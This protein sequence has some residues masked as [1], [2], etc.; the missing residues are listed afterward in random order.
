MRFCSR[1]EHR[2]AVQDRQAMTDDSAS[3]QMQG[4]EVWCLMQDPVD[5]GTFI[6]LVGIFGRTDPDSVPGS[7]KSLVLRS[8][9]IASPA[10]CVMDGDQGT[11][12]KA[13]REGL[14]GTLIEFKIVCGVEESEIDHLP[15]DVGR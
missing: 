12:V 13:R 7:G 5:E 3:V 14:P 8:K 1:L 9:A 15:F 2:S 11:R 6:R 4:G 10:A